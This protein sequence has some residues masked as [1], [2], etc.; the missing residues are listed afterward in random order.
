[1]LRRDDGKPRRHR[2]Q[3]GDGQALLVSG[4]GIEH[5][6]LHEDVAV[7]QQ[8]PNGGGRLP[9]VQRHD[10]LET[11][12]LH[13][14]PRGGEEGAAA[15][16]VEPQLR[17][18]PVRPAERVEEH[19][20]RLLR[21][22][23]SDRDAADDGARCARVRLGGDVYAAR[24]DVNPRRVEPELHEPIAAHTADRDHAVGRVEAPIRLLPAWLAQ[25]PGDVVAVGVRVEPCADAS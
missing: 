25:A 16:V 19:D 2:L 8:A 21:D 7:P 18:H 1:V 9:A 4:F 13:E 24:H 11:Q 14:L 12:R 15:D 5:A 20:R 6:V 23:A 17:T 10:R 22:H 3:D